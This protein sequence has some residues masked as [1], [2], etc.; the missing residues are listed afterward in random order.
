MP[1]HYVHGISTNCHSLTDISSSNV[2]ASKQKSTTGWKIIDGRKTY[3]TFRGGK[4]VQGDGREGFALA[5]SD[6]KAGGKKRKH[7]EEEE[8]CT[9]DQVRDEFAG[10]GKEN[11]I[12]SNSRAR[13]KLTKGNNGPTRSD[14]AKRAPLALAVNKKED[15][16]NIRNYFTKS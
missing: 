15:T 5:L 7:T 8:G 10:A 14:G 6:E 2:A 3:T 16:A 11:N 1:S 13:S 4:L 9:R 12:E